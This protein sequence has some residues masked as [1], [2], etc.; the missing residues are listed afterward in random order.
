MKRETAYSK[1]IAGVFD[2]AAGKYDSVGPAIFSYFG[3]RLVEMSG[4][5][6]GAKVLDAG[7]GRGAV[8]FPAAR[9]VGPGGGVVGID[10]SR[11][12][13]RQTKKRIHG[14]GLK[15]VFV[16]RMD[17][18]ELSFM[19]GCFD[20]IMCGFSL[21]FCPRPLDALREFKRVLVKKG[22]VGLTSRA[23]DRET[24]WLGQLIER[25]VPKNTIEDGNRGDKAL[26]PDLHTPTGI[27]CAMSAAGFT[28]IRI[29][30]IQEFFTYRNREEW[31]ASQWANGRR[32]CLEAMGPGNLEEFKIEVSK[33]LAYYKK[34]EGI[35]MPFRVI[36]AFGSNA[37]LPGET[38]RARDAG[39]CNG[40]HGIPP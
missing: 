3:E 15:N 28:N 6:P 4:I 16:L 12:M 23:I 21:F 9:K 14:S 26:L 39:T 29:I 25:F 18:R 32:R 7:T 37:P 31:W 36:A 40:H 1:D 24:Q 34:K 20:F 5:F 27:E 22:E 30:E 11:E 13:V 35:R 17:A 19:G 8:L 10:I 38:G 2:R 33:R